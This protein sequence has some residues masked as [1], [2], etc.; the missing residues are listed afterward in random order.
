LTSSSFD[1]KGISSYFDEYGEREWN[2]L[3]ETPVDEISLYIHRQYLRQ[4]IQHGARV[5]EIGA[6]AG[7]FTLALA[8]I[9]ARVLVADISPGQ[10]GLNR[11]FAAELGFASAVED[12]LELDIC[13]LS[14][15]PDSAFD[16]VVAY[17]GPFSYVLDRRDAALSECLRVLKP[18]GRLL[19]SVMSLWG[20]ARRD[21]PGVLALPVEINQVI[22]TTGELTAAVM[23]ARKKNQMHLFRAKEVEDWLLSAG[24]RILAISA[25]GVLAAVWDAA[26][27]AIRKNQTQWNELLR[28][29]LEASADP[30]CT[31]LG[32]HL[33]FAAEKIQDQA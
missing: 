7:R 3:V 28:M 11:R 18:G 29:E 2:R 10:L 20:S 30:G 8:E 22:T 21:L 16:N 27:P 33:I 13:D 14:V 32:T 17:G 12:W 31:G 1:P 19:A 23:P 15:F 6:G 4:Y 9:G 24:L 25:S 5:L 26:L